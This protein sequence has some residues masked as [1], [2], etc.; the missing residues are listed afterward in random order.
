MIIITML[1]VLS[2]GKIIFQSKKKEKLKWSWM[3]KCAYA[4]ERTE[5]KHQA[6]GIG[7]QIYL[8]KHRKALRNIQVYIRKNKLKVMLESQRIEDFCTTGN[9]IISVD[10][11]DNIHVDDDDDIMDA[12]ELWGASRYFWWRDATKYE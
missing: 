9:S 10:F 7:K 12:T 11:D 2:A 5:H 1:L 4:Y 6:N 3:R 8:G